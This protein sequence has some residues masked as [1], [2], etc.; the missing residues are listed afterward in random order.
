MNLGGKAR[1]RARTADVILPAN[2]FTGPF[3][4]NLTLANDEPP[5]E[6]EM[7]GGR[8]TAD[9]RESSAIDFSVRNTSANGAQ[10]R[11]SELQGATLR[12][13]SRA[14]ARSPQRRRRL[15]A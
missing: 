9:W 12:D 5:R 1:A 3:H 4:S 11:I 10:P 15:G 13:R 8:T 2:G 7:A 14:G 6:A